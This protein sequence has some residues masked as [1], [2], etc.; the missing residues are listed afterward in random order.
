MKPVAAV[1][2]SLAPSE[3]VTET[4]GEKQFRQFVFIQSYKTRGVKK[5]F[6]KCQDG[7]RKSTCLETG[8]EACAQKSPVISSVTGSRS[9]S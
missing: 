3:A 5:P 6:G 8:H 2:H 9:M 1:L 4:P 7:R